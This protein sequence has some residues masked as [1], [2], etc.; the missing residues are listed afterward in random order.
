MKALC[1][2]YLILSL[3]DLILTGILY[4]L[5][6]LGEVNLV[7]AWILGYGLVACTCYKA[8]VVAGVLG[9]L[10]WIGQHSPRTH[11]DLLIFANGVNAAVVVYSTI[12]V[13]IALGANSQSVAM[14]LGI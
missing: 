4:K 2:S 12:L 3:F 9:V 10:R 11:R 5:G 6:T 1:T 7:A 8:S 13:G 14:T